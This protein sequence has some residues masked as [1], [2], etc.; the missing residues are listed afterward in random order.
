MENEVV[1]VISE[2]ADVED[3]KSRHEKEESADRQQENTH[4]VVLFTG[5]A[6][7]S[8]V[9]RN[10]LDWM[11]QLMARVNKAAEDKG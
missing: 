10:S 8:S 6:S 1:F 11:Q 4:E 9:P 5:D 3:D 7:T 2:L